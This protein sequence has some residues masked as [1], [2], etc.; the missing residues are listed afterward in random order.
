MTYYQKLI[1]IFWIPLGL[2][3]GLFELAND[4]ARDLENKR[5]FPRAIIGKNC[6]FTREVVIGNYTSIFDYNTIN[7]STIGFCSYTNFDCII[8]N[9]KIG[10]YCSIAHG[11]RIGLDPIRQIYFL[12]PGFFINLIISLN[13]HY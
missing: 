8:Q 7:H 3:K 12:Q 10:N 6:S 13:H 2:V 9:S 1:R 4:K 5:R 11:V